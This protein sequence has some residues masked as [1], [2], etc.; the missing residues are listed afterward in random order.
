MLEESNV[1]AGAKRNATIP[2]A[3]T[4]ATLQIG[5]GVVKIDE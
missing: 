4:K 1:S 3:R 5:S 2:G